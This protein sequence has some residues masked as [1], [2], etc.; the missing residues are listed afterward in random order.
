MSCELWNI[1]KRLWLIDSCWKLLFHCS[2]YV[3][4]AWFYLSYS[5]H[6]H[7]NMIF[8]Q[9]AYGPPKHTTSTSEG[10]RSD[11]VHPGAAKASSSG[12]HYAAKS[13]TSLSSS[14]T[15]F[16]AK[17]SAPSS[18]KLTASSPG[19]AKNSTALPPKPQ[20]VGLPRYGKRAAS[21]SSASSSSISTL[22]IPSNNNSNNKFWPFDMI[23][24]ICKPKPLHDSESHRHYVDHTL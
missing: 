7:T 18:Q 5:S 6:G 17:S 8:R 13:T 22:I 23:T 12:N 11:T 15:T 16:T 20:S 4:C 24:S 21:T 14:T 9:G 3:R 2:G 1:Y 19:S 10:S